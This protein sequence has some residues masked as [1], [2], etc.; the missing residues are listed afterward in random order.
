MQELALV[1]EL[2][3]SRESSYSKTSPASF[4]DSTVEAMFAIEP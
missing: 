1:Y 4:A 3:R 2:A